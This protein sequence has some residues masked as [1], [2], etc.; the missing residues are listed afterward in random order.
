MITGNRFEGTFTGVGLVDEPEIGVRWNGAVGTNGDVGA[1]RDRR[2]VQ[3]VGRWIRAGP[4][5]RTAGARRDRGHAQRRRDP[6]E[7]HR[8][9]P[10]RR[11][12]RPDLVHADRTGSG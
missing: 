3:L 7:H 2:R 5:R 10:L 8:H 6:V 4:Q 9:R 12:L 11:Q 1:E